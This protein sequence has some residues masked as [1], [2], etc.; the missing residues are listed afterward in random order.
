VGAVLVAAAGFVLSRGYGELIGKPFDEYSRVYLAQLRAL[1]PGVEKDAYGLSIINQTWLFFQYGL[2]WFFP[3]SGW[4][5]VS[6][7]PAFPIAW[8]S[9]PQIL[10]VAAYLG[11]IIGG[12]F[13]LMRYRDWRAL[14]AISLLFPALL[15][16]T[17]FAT[18]WVQDP[19][20]LYRSYLWA[21]GIPGLVFFLLH[22]TPP[23]MLIAIGLVVASV[24]T[25]QALDRVFSM[26]TQVSVWSD[27]IEKL[28]KD[29]RS[30]GRWFPYLNRGAAYVDRDEFKLALRDF[31]ASA[32]LGDG[33]VGVFNM[34]AVYLATNQPAP[35]LAAFDRAEK[36]GYNLYNLPMERGMALMALG[37]I[38]EAH[39]QF[40]ITRQFNPPSPT[41]EVLWL[42]LARSEV[43]LGRNDEAIANAGRLL[44]AQPRSDEA[45][46]VQAMAY[47]SK[48]D[49]ARARELLD[50]WLA[51][52][53]S[54][55]ALYARAMAN[56]GLKRKPEALADIDRALRLGLDNPTMR[57]WKARIQAMP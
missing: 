52:G 29:S 8:I 9:F 17:E 40:E 55:S 56:Y 54:A 32:A 51:E 16:T 30:V 45:K 11:T 35:A 33:G 48:G 2:R 41:R 18:V 34:G 1:A 37:R 53:E 28:P 3:F 20:V 15:F 38:A 42:Q 27:A 19:F 22:G 26:A 21:I 12:F 23:R 36:D 57:Q 4:L 47:I 13:V 49:A 31:E 39:G 50:A 5:S 44:K 7:R 43:Q 24:F 6:L 14:V 46:Y 25:W 10:G